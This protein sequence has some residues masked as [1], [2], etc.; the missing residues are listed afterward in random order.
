MKIGRIEISAGAM[1]AVA[2]LYYLDDSGVTLWVLMAGAV[3]EIGHCLAI[4]RLGGKVSRLRF[5]CAGVE[6][7]LSAAHPLSAGGMIL[8]ALAGPAVNL[9]I[10][11]L[12]AVLAK[13]GAGEELYFF[14][15][16]NL[17][18]ASF[19]LLPAKWL[20]GGRVMGNLMVQIGKE[21]LG[22]RLVELCSDAVAALLL[23]AGTVLLWQSQGRNFTLLIAGIWMA[24]RARWERRTGML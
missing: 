23:G 7:C 21:E 3:H 16:L 11:W 5:S 8:A 4:W 1:M 10:A 24:N 12:S 9:G 17:G 19:N 22:E 15:G 6:L 20:D 2:L 14:A 18:L 13:R